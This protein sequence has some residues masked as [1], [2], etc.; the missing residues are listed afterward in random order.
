[1]T[2]RFFGSA[3]L[4]ASILCFSGCGD[5]KAAPVSGKVTL[6]GK[7]VA[8]AYVAFEPASG[9]RVATGL[10]DENGQFTLSCYDQNDGAA[11]GLN[12]VAIVKMDEAVETATTEGMDELET[13]LRLDAPTPASQWLI[14]QK[15]ASFDTSELTFTV[16]KRN[17]SANFPLSSR[18]E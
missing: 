10:T 17:E 14:P 15:Y 13:E 6:D 1:M 16:N 7:P 4:L 5:P 8:G 18:T 2:L 9:K 12:R 3:A 11:L